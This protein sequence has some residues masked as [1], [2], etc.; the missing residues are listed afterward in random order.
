MS[1]TQVLSEH[2]QNG[3]MAPHHLTPHVNLLN[4]QIFN[5]TNMLLWTLGLPAHR[6][7]GPAVFHFAQVSLMDSV[8][9][10]AAQGR[11]VSSAP[12]PCSA[13]IR[14][15]AASVATL[16][17]ATLA[18]THITRAPPPSDPTSDQPSSQ[19]FVD[20]RRVPIKTAR[21]I[22]HGGQSAA[23]RTGTADFELYRADTM[24]GIDLIA[25][26]S[27]RPALTQPLMTGSLQS[28]RPIAAPDAGAPCRDTDVTSTP[29]VGG[30]VTLAVDIHCRAGQAWTIHYGTISF[31]RRLD[32]RGRGTVTMDLFQGTKPPLTVEFE[33]AS[34]AVVALPEFAGPGEV[35]RFAKVT[36][37]W[38]GPIQL[39][40]HAY[41]Y[42]A[43]H[44]EP[45]HI[46][47][48]APGSAD[49]ARTGTD[50]S[51]RARGFLTRFDDDVKHDMVGRGDTPQ[52]KAVNR[53]FAT[54]KLA[55]T[56]SGRHGAKAQTY[57]VLHSPTQTSGTIT[58]AVDYASRGQHPLGPACDDG[59][60][61]RPTY[62][63]YRLDPD[64]TVHH[65]TQVLP[66][67]KCGTALA[68]RVRYQTGLVPDLKLR[69]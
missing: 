45:G 49:R 48:G 26:K 6:C 10:R 38:Q 61:A 1:I 63:I 3:T 34:P 2:V 59:A 57:T 14:L 13:P 42:A 41:E 37:L 30:R 47:S 31:A 23:A 67:A 20:L 29:L 56:D 44:G 24:S 55:A 51:Q 65:E 18:Y 46:W 22:E 54:P 66:P 35:P 7:Q 8:D 52:T 33:R 62:Q 4:A 64:G 25:P 9:S 32:N 19:P 28:V 39:D 43:G 53:N 27:A 58:L 36:V 21:R 68:D 40:L 60:L 15:A 50:T 16:L 11:A 5:N 12:K 17:V 69:R